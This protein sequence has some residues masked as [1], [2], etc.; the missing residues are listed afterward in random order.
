MGM[1]H[2]VT[3]LEQRL[4]TTIDMLPDFI[5]PPAALSLS[6]LARIYSG[7]CIQTHKIFVRGSQM[8]SKKLSPLAVHSNE[9]TVLPQRIG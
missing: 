7:E 2:L 3:N 5:P 6:Y 9:T 4:T 1:I 8:I